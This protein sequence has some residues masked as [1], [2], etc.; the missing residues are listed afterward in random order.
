MT[1]QE[2]T[3][4]Y[5]SLTNL[6]LEEGSLLRYVDGEGLNVGFVVAV[7][8]G[9]EFGIEEYRSYPYKVLDT[10]SD[11]LKEDGLPTIKYVGSEEGLAEYI[12]HFTSFY[13]QRLHEVKWVDLDDNT[14]TNYGKGYWII[15]REYKIYASGLTLTDATEY[16]K[17]DI[18]NLAVASENPEED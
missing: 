8:D 18:D 5:H 9:D 15:D 3:K 11:R 16:L 12:S 4:K 10:L 2:Y 7:G 1:N 6:H 13:Y 14:E 17:K